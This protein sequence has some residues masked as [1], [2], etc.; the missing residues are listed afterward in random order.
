MVAPKFIVAALWPLMLLGGPPAVA[1]SPVWTL[2]SATRRALAVAP[3]LGAAR[4]EVAARAGELDQAGAW[5]NPSIELRADQKLGIDDG[6]GGNDLTQVAITQPLPLVRL[7]YQRRVAQGRVDAARA[8]LQHRRLE[9]EFA[10]ARALH[11]LQWASAGMALAEERVKYLDAVPAG[12]GRRRDPLVRYLSPVER[13]RLEILRE[14]AQQD[15]AQAEGRYAEAGFAFRGV[16]TLPPDAP[17]AVAPLSLPAPP[18]EAAVLQAGV[19]DH[20]AIEA[21]RAGREAARAAVSAVRAQRLAD[22]A[23]T[24]FRERDYLAGARREYSGVM[25]S[26]QLPLWDRRSGAVAAAQAEAERAGFDAQLLERDYGLRLAQSR[27]HLAHLIE[28]ADN[29]RERLLAPAQRVLE[30][31]QRGFASGEIN[32]LTLIDAHNTYYDAHG[33][34]LTL[35]LEAG[36]EAAELRR[37][38]GL[39]L[40][41]E[42]AP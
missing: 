41:T 33:R 24:V 36:L 13:A 34:Y 19:A 38:A 4:A 21:A 8:G 27:L 31:S 40:L 1:E 14:A 20:P 17:V 42:V 10:V 2:E 39:S 7:R 6:R 11:Q 26:V 25:L 29:Q 12:D 28:Q 9:L 16:L 32:L 37:A 15:L 3:E 22:P 23:V 30:M 18:A 5:P 35:L